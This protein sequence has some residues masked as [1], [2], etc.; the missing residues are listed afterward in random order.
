MPA[1][2]GMSP[3]VYWQEE[4]GGVRCGFRGGEKMTTLPEMKNH[5]CAWSFYYEHGNT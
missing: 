4:G 3:G 1:N 5:T 2:P